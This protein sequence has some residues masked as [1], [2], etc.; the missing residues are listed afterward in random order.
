[1]VNLNELKKRVKEDKKY[2]ISEE[3][4]QEELIKIL[5]FYDID[6]DR[7]MKDKQSE[8][9]GENILDA[10]IEYLRLG[11]IEIQTTNGFEII[12]H[13]VNGEKLVYA[14]IQAK[15]KREMDKCEVNGN[16]KIYAFMGALCGLGTGAIDKLHANDLAVVEV[17]GAIFLLA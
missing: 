12:H 5:K 4:A 11:K 1:M 15:Y 8:N 2:K 17:V 7:F 14:Q 6:I 13:L 16:S 3:S 9:V 10:I